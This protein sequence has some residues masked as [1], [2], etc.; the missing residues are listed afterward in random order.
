MTTVDSRSVAG[1]YLR[2]GL[3]A[4]S[5]GAAAIHFSVL[6]SHFAEYW[7]YGLFFL[8]VAWAQV[9]WAVAA[10]SRPARVVLWL[11]AAGNAA[12][13]AAYVAS[14]T[15][16]VPIG[17][18][19]GHPEPLGGLDVVCA[20]FETVLV[21]GALAALRRSVT[22]HLIGP[23]HARALAIGVG[24]AVVAAATAVSFPAL[25]G[26]EGAGSKDSMSSP[27]TG[28]QPM[29]M[30]EVGSTA[31]PSAAQIAAA[32][33]LIRQTT[34]GIAQ[35]QNI[36]AAI[37]AGYQPLNGT[38]N[39]T[40][41]I[42]QRYVGRG[43]DPQH[44]ASLVYATNV[45]G[46][47]P[48]LL[49]AMYMVRPGV[50][51]PDIGGSLTRWHEHSIACVS[52]QLRVSGVQVTRACQGSSTPHYTMQMLHVWTVPNYPGGPFSDDLS[53]KAIQAGIQQALSG[54]K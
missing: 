4:M 53:G 9:A 51:G 31:P 19:A 13:L 52:G 2:T 34:A 16:G 50:D 23:V 3:A 8:V 18:G 35:Y 46:H 36:Q 14:R 43:I 38:V 32:D 6:F 33:Q 5:V 30:R 21:I 22:H 44:P 48:I 29:A 10:V 25:A 11:G 37:T 26:P 49:G 7:M 15:T 17:P 27:T 20:V 42:N 24:A 47:P 28:T 1:P 41:Y 12:V 45:P 39:E 40:H 54:Q